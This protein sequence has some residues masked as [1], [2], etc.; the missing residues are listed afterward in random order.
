MTLRKWAG[1][2]IISVLLCLNVFAGNETDIEA[3][4]PTRDLF[5]PQQIP[6][7]FYNMSFK[8]YER[9]DLSF[10]MLVPKD[11][12]GVPIK[13]SEKQMKQEENSS[14]LPLCEIRAPDWNIS[15]ARIEV[16]SVK[17]PAGVTLRDWVD[18]YLKGNQLSPIAR[19]AGT[20]NG[21]KVE[22]VLFRAQQGKKSFLVRTTFSCHGF[23]IF[24]VACSSLEQSF[25]KYAKV[26]SAAAISFR[27]RKAGL[28]T[29]FGGGSDS[30]GKTATQFNAT[31]L[32]N[33]T[34]ELF[35]QAIHSNDF[36]KFYDN[37]ASSLRKRATAKDIA[38]AFSSFVDNRVDLLFTKGLKPVFEA[39]PI[40]STNN[41]LRL[42]GKYYGTSMTVKFDLT[43]EYED[44]KWR[45]SDISIRTGPPEAPPG[46]KI[47]PPGKKDVIRLVNSTMM[48]LAQCINKND[49]EALYNTIATVWKRQTTKD[50]LRDIFS[51]FIEKNIDLSAL[52]G[53]KPVFEKEPRIEQG[54]LI[55]KGY[56][57]SEKMKTY[58]KLNYWMEGKNWRL[59]GIDVHTR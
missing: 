20:F 29:C 45:L 39:K 18:L 14:L 52:E 1:M 43:Y 53:K 7:V 6:K 12:S 22:D 38:R 21:R 30:R 33:N 16:H 55:V 15:T 2:S 34:M 11:W 5:S 49:F 57:T 25:K 54:K 3:L 58:F 27:P 56:Y 59:M 4:W 31:S 36:A 37:C 23:R 47:L 48:I 41:P 26:F 19:R 44:S 46:V 8:P 32:V 51:S 35:A 24:L 40:I 9:E 28:K 10:M 13:L 50:K 42:K 17:I